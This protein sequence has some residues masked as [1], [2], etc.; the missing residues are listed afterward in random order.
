MN[1][2]ILTVHATPQAATVYRAAS[3][4]DRRKSD[5]LV[6]LQLTEFAKSHESLATV[7]DAMSQEAVKVGL[8]PDIQ[9]SILHGS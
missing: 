3:G 4:E 7:M 5:R 1:T 6:S 8:T 9:G 2:E